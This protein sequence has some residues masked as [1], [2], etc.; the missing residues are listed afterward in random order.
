MREHTH[1]KLR[2]AWAKYPFFKILLPYLIGIVLADSIFIQEKILGVIAFCLLISLIALHLGSR[3]S[4]VSSFAFGIVAFLFWLVFSFLWTYLRDERNLPRHYNVHLSTKGKPSNEFITRTYYLEE[5][6]RYWDCYSQVLTQM[7]SNNLQPVLGNLLIRI[8]KSYSY[9]PMSR[10]IYQGKFSLLVPDGAAAPYEFDWKVM[11][12]RRNIHWITYADTS[13]LKVI[14]HAEPDWLETWRIKL[15]NAIRNIITNARDYPVASAMLIGLRKK[16]DPELYRAYSATGAVHVLSVSGMHVGILAGILELIFGFFKSKSRTSRI[17]KSI[18]ILCIIW[19]YT[20]LTG[21]SPP[22][23]RSAFMFTSFISARLIQRDAAPM[24]ILAGTAFIL[25]IIN[26]LDVF[27]IGFQLSFG[28]MA[29]IYLLYEPIRQLVSTS[30]SAIQII[31][32]IIAVSL[33]AQLMIYPVVGYHFHQF[34]FYFWLTGIIS[35]PFSFIILVGGMVAI[36]VF[37]LHIPILHFLYYPLIYSVRWMNDII[38]WVYTLP[39]GQV[40]GWWPDV[41][42]S[43]ILIIISILFVQWLM[44]KSNTTF[45]YLLMTLILFVTVMI[46][47]EYRDQRKI[48][49]IA[50]NNRNHLKLWVKHQMTLIQVAGDSTLIESNYAAKYNIQSTHIIR[51]DGAND[52]Y[53]SGPLKISPKSIIIDSTPITWIAKSSDTLQNKPNQALLFLPKYWRNKANK[54][55]RP[56]TVYTT[57][58]VEHNSIDTIFPYSKV[59]FSKKDFVQISIQ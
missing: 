9:I 23:V 33:S 41:L 56:V 55:I 4:Q 52:T 28:A 46:I 45:R 47:H 31:W 44:D 16:M 21:A 25:L 1:T 54:K 48:E 58:G 43:G 20:L 51:I 27:N 11:L 19:V 30:N 2:I 10:D 32:K 39:M 8:P 40:S 36:P 59:N 22:I 29:G 34:A 24:N 53:K 3:H 26:P 35:S 50:T 5:K 18:L 14:R 13:L 38:A 57:S 37:L 42:D 15:D 49:I 6:D 12:H 17:I 7:D